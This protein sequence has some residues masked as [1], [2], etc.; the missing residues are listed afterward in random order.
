MLRWHYRSRH[1]SLITVSNNE[2]YDNRL[3]VFP[4]PDKGREDVGLRFRH[5]PT[6]SYKRERGG[7][8]NAGESRA[9]ARAVMEHAQTSPDLTLGVAA[10]SLTQA[11]RIEDELEILRRGDPSGEPFFAAHSEEPFFIKNLENV[12]GDE[13]D[14]ILISVGYGK[15][16]GGYMPMNFEPLNKDGGERRLNV[17][18]TRARRRCVVYSNFVADDLD[19]RRTNTRGVQSLKTFLEYAQT[20]D[21]HIPQAS[22]READSPFEEAVTGKLRER[23]YAVDQQVGSAGFF[24]DLAVV[25]PQ[26]PGRYLLGIECDGASYHSARSA[27]DRDRLRQQVLEGL[28]WTIHRIW[29]TDWFRNP[30]RELAKMRKLDRRHPEYGFGRHKGYGTPEHQKAIRQHGLLPMHRK[31]FLFLEEV[32]GEYSPLFYQLKTELGGVGSEDGLESL[33]KELLSCRASLESQ[34]T[35]KLRILLGRRRQ[36]FR[37]RDGTG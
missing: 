7:R 35:R 24:I 37:G 27:R 21:L 6:V 1:E 25:D 15:V 8:F 3:V 31:S 30:Q 5:D 4:S 19:M 22:G 11:R 29:S 10:F 16:E 18:I 9:V 32:R 28:G 23:G 17:L 36:Q 14:V 13:R 34:E 20:G 2:F 26:R 12:Q 33:E